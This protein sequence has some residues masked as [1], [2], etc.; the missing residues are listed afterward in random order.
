MTEQTTTPGA[1]A[2]PDAEKAPQLNLQPLVD[3]LS[4]EAP[5][6]LQRFMDNSHV[7]HRW[8]IWLAV[9]LVLAMSALAGIAIWKG[10]NDTA[11]KIVIALVS[12]L[13]GTAFFGSTKQ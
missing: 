13:G 8:T 5:R 7:G 10:A 4:P 2:A 9:T 6:L 12:F 11:E 1:P 3:S